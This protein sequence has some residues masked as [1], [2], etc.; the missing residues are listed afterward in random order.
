MSEGLKALY[1]IKS[2]F[3]RVEEDD[4][5]ILH[6]WQEHEKATNAIEK[7]LKALEVVRKLFSSSSIYRYKL[8]D[9]LECGWITEEEYSLL[10]DVL[11][12]NAD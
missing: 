8:K 12:D 10:K 1:A 3:L 9:S 5:I 7:E 4:G 6:V 2:V 11:Q